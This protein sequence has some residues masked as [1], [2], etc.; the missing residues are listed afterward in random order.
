[1]LNAVS[2]NPL[3]EALHLGWKL[4]LLLCVK[5]TQMLQASVECSGLTDISNS[6]FSEK[7]LLLENEISQHYVFFANCQKQFFMV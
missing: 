5:V 2:R 7:A 6:R 3:S 1:M 4:R